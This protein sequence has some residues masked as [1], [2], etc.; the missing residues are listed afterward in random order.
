MPG[1]LKVL[2]GI[3]G[4]AVVLSALGSDWA[5]AIIYGLVMFGVWRGNE[6]VRKLL[7]VVGWLGLIFN[8]I[9]AA[10]ALVAS[11]ALSGLALIALVNFVWGCA[12]CAYMIWCLG[13][14][15]V[16]HWMFNRS[17]NLT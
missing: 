7:I 8:G 16:Q 12:Y 4:V 15:D 5:R 2:L 14:Q 11:V 17:L 3:I 9:A 1:K 13:Q 6:T 10:M